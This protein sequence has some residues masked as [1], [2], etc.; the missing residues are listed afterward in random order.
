MGQKPDN[1]RL[2]KTTVNEHLASVTLGIGPHSSFNQFK[3]GFV[4]APS[5]RRPIWT[6]MVAAKLN[7][8]RVL[9][10]KFHQNRSMLKGRSAGQTDLAYASDDLETVPLDDTNM[11][12][13]TTPISVNSCNE[14]YNSTNDNTENQTK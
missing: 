12:V 1:S 6:I 14:F 5:P 11:S 2:K 7:H 10:T 9:V 8:R 13:T 3:N 4:S